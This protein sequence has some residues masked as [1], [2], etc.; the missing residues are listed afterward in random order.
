MSWIVLGL[1]TG[2]AENFVPVRTG[3]DSHPASCAVGNQCFPGV[4]RTGSGTEHPSQY[5]G[6]VANQLDPNFRAPL[7]LHRHTV[8]VNLT[9]Y[10][11][12]KCSNREASHYTV[13]ALHSP[14]QV[15]VFSSQPVA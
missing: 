15:Q 7:Y 5:Y 4:K 14:P 11:S 10:Y 3:P 9:Y 1:N 2:A 8:G 6:V 12:A 13:L